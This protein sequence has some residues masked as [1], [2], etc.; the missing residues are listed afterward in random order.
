MALEGYSGTAGDVLDVCKDAENTMYCIDGMNFTTMDSHP[1]KVVD[2]NCGNHQHSGWWGNSCS[3][4]NLNALF[5][6]WDGKDSRR[7][8]TW[9]KQNRNEG[10]IVYSEMKIKYP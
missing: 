3:G 2:G 6:E 9:F 8:M 4:S 10:G 7:Y 5:G 1:E